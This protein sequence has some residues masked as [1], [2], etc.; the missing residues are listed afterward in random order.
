MTRA[1][2]RGCTTEGMRLSRAALVG[3]ALCA[4]ATAPVGAEDNRPPMVEIEP[5]DPPPAPVPPP[6]TLTPPAATHQIDPGSSV[7]Q[8]FA[9]ALPARPTP[10][11]VFFL[12]D[13][14]ASQEESVV[15]LARG[16]ARISREL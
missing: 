7:P 3:V 6:A 10:L 16:I 12:V 15:G 4:L 9:L 11:D 14:S 1:G 13:T 5:F 2:A 8:D